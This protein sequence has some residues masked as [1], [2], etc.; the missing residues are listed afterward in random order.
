MIEKSHEGDPLTLEAEMSESEQMYLITTAMLIEDGMEQPVPLPAL[1]QARSIMPAS[2]NQMVRKLADEGLVTYIPYKGI[3]LTTAGTNIATRILRYRRLW[4]VF[5]VK[6]LKLALPSA[7]QLACR[8]EHLTTDE[9]A[10]RLSEYL[11]DPQLSPQGKPIPRAPR[12]DDGGG[13][14]C[15]NQ[16][17]VGQRSRVVQLKGEGVAR[18]FLQGEGILPGALV[19]ALA[20]GGDGSVLLEVDGRQSHLSASIADSVL[21]QIQE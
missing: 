10:D 9:V 20:L 12:E 16:T 2:V 8:L 1:A 14:L 4:E 6:K 17:R 18:G 7:D 5:L 21:V 19:T 3:V 13:V 15:V 11:G